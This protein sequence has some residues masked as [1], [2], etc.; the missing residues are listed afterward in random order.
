MFHTTKLR[1]YVGLI[2]II[3]VVT[4]KAS[5]RQPNGYML[6]PMFLLGVISARMRGNKERLKS[7]RFVSIRQSSR[8]VVIMLLSCYEDTNRFFMRETLVPATDYLNIIE[9]VSRIMSVGH[10]LGRGLPV[11]RINLYL[12]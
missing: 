3:Y 1:F 7:T 12:F 4:V 5:F 11:G 6:V 2:T 9:E 10:I 8:I